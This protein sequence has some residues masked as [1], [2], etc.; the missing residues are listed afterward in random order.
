MVNSSQAS[1][2][3]KTTAEKSFDDWKAELIE[4]AEAKTRNN[5]GN[6]AGKDEDLDDKGIQDIYA[7]LFPNG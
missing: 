6:K 7:K 4:K 2:R 3:R 5:P 1:F